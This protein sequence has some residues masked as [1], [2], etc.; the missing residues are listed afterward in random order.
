[1][2]KGLLDCS[3]QNSRSAA[4]RSRPGCS[5]LLSG[6]P[7]G[8][9]FLSTGQKYMIALLAVYLALLAGAPVALGDEPPAIDPEI[10]AAAVRA[11]G[12]PCDRPH[13]RARLGGEPAGSRGLDPALRDDQLS[14]DL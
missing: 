12:F 5:P 14:Y 9:L 2:E 3:S 13:G 4:G 7:V 10:I 11:R 6:Q 1:M 8:A